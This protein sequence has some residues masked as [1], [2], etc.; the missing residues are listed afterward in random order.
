[1]APMTR[2]HART[3][4]RNCSNAASGSLASNTR[5]LI[6]RETSLTASSKQPR[7]WAQP[8]ESAPPYESNPRRRN[9]AS[10]LDSSGQQQLGA[11]PGSRKT[12]N[13]RI[14]ET[15][16]GAPAARHSKP[17]C[18]KSQARVPGG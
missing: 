5:G 10:A 17:S 16:G 12:L 13:E 6:S 18:R 14:G 15:Q 9:I 4:S 8:S 11:P 7:E 2:L 1:M 3:F